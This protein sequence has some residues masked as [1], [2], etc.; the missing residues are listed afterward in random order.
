MK[1]WYGK[2]FQE[3][4]AEGLPQQLIPFEGILKDKGL[5]R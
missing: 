2:Y 4:Q 1:N 3:K 5:P